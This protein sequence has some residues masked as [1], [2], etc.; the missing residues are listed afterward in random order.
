MHHNFIH[1]ITNDLNTAIVFLKEMLAY[2]TEMMSD[3][4]H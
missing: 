1:D 3:I 2:F 4:E